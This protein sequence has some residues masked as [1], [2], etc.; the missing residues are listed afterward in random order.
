MILFY[1]FVLA[2]VAALF[3]IFFIKDVLNR[4][5][6]VEFLRIYWITRDNGEGQPRF[7]KATMRQ[8]AAPYW[9]GRGWQFRFGKYTFQIGVLTV[10][11]DS[12][13]SQIS[14]LGWLETEPKLLR[15]WGDK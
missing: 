13:E 12:M 10:K 11:V 9:R 5:Q 14:N 2:F 6:Y 1:L 8:T 4:I 15:R 7:A 3:Y